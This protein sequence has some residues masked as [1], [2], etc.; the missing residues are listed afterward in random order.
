MVI[1]AIPSLAEVYPLIS[2][3]ETCLQALK[4]HKVFYNETP[5]KACSG[6]MR[7]MT[8][9]HMLRC[10]NCRKEETGRAHSFFASSRLKL[11]E[12]LRLGYFW[13][14][15]LGRDQTVV[16]TKHSPR[17]VTNF[18]IYF[19]QL[20]SQ[21]LE[22]NACVIGGPGI[23]VEI[24][25]TKMGKRKYHRGHRVEGVWLLGGVEKT[26]QR[27]CFVIPVPDRT[28]ETIQQAI[29]S[30]VLPGSI[31]R[32]DCWKS[33]SYLGSSSEYIHQAVNHSL[34]FTDPAT[35]VNTNTIEGT[36][37]GLKRK[38]PV[39]NRVQQGMEGQIMEF[40]WRRIHQDRLWDALLDA[41]RD[42]YYE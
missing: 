42:V 4:N 29:Q 28:T 16:V 34:H 41:F 39:R 30:H 12:I 11:H 36:W 35:G 38:V 23:V 19:R 21:S 14:L 17:I 32:T 27:K 3:E 8:G 13:L 25:E 31:I 20:V 15:G 37:A 5:C 40:I 7:T 24:D 18:F 6:T 1:P 22:E 2:D 9:R 26:P 10:S 33:Y